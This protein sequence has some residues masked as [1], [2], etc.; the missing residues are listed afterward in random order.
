[1]AYATIQLVERVLAQALTS[2]TNSVANG[3]KIPLVDFGNLRNE[4]TISED[5]INQYIQWSDEEVDGALSEMYQV[6]LCEKAD[7][8]MMPLFSI[9]EYYLSLDVDKAENLVPGDVI[10]I[11]DD[12]QE[13]RHIVDMV[14][15]NTTVETVDT[16]VGTYEASETRVIR[17]KFPPPI[18]LISARLAAANIYD[19]YFAA[20]VSPNVSD[21]GKV[22]R[23]QA[24]RDLNNIL[25]GRT[26]LHGQRRIGHRFLNPN[27]RD[28]YRLPGVTDSDSTRDIGKAES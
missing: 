22:L 23:G 6:P 3:D 21:Y 25:N 5:I 19:K 26:V 8:E 1:M 12:T 10:V 7:L 9:G 14:V 2:A 4:N 24:I 11:F 16:I 28:R 15:N 20:Q 27:L 17:V 13:E 18:P